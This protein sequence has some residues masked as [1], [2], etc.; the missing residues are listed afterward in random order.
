MLNSQRIGWDM[1]NHTPR[2]ILF[3]QWAKAFSYWCVIS[4]EEAKDMRAVENIMA[5]IFMGLNCHSVQGIT[6]QLLNNGP[7][8]VGMAQSKESFLS[9]I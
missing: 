9:E 8:R 6:R 5:V 7:H 2:S 1:L 3:C 4:H